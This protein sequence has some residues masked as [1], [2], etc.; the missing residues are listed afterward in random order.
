MAVDSCDQDFTTEL[1]G[2]FPEQG[3]VDYFPDLT[4]P[5]PIGKYSV[6]YVHV[7]ACNNRSDT[8]HIY[9]ELK[10]LVS[11]TPI[12]TDELR[13]SMTSGNF[14]IRPQD[15][16]DGTSDNCG[17]EHI[18]IRRSVCGNVNIFEEEVNEFILDTYGG[19]IPFNGWANFVEVGCCDI[20]ELVRVQLMAIDKAGNHNF[21]WTSIFP[22]E[23]II[24]INYLMNRSGCEWMQHK[25]L[26]SMKTLA[27]L[28]VL[29]IL[30]VMKL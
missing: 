25:Q 26:C 30:V 20:N 24:T 22:E 15:I 18:F 23:T 11:P 10:D 13:V 17:I 21:C 19:R 28:F 16:D 2:L 14:P 7:D 29:T 6:A 1:V 27:I 8:C 12:C 4:A 9:F 5:I 3:S